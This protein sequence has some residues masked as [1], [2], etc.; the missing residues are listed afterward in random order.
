[1]TRGQNKWEDLQIGSSTLHIKSHLLSSFL[2][3]LFPS[4]LSSSTLSPPLPFRPSQPPCP[5]SSS[6]PSLLSSPPNPTHLLSLLAYPLPSILPSPLLCNIAKCEPSLTVRDDRHIIPLFYYLNCVICFDV[7]G[8][9][10]STKLG[11]SDSDKT[12]MRV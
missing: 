2:Q 5:L 1:M 4:F 11:K 9:C 7:N 6:P 10:E 12:R 8:F 3:S